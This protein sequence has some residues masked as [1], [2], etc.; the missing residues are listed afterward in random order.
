MHRTSRRISASLFNSANL[1]V[2]VWQGCFDEI[3][4]GERE[5]ERER[6]RF[7]T[8]RICIFKDAL[9]PNSRGREYFLRYVM[10]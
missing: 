10:S 1:K 6:E 7:S 5:R 3:Y 9:R 8:K 4:N 2:S